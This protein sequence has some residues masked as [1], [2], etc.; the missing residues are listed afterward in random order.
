MFGFSIIKV[1]GFLCVAFSYGL[2]LLKHDFNNTS[3][4]EGQT[5]AA[6]LTIGPHPIAF[7]GNGL[8]RLGHYWFS[9]Q[10]HW[11]GH[12]LIIPPGGRCIRTTGRPIC[13]VWHCLVGN[14]TGRQPLCHWCPP[15]HLASTYPTG[16]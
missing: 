7:S 11:H 2:I 12:R 14:R 1:S 13:T 8:H 4:C 5:R 15:A 6:A 3:C 16:I 9:C 10:C